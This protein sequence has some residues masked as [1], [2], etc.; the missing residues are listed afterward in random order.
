MSKYKS[1][2]GG[3][4]EVG[5]GTRSVFEGKI[6]LFSKFGDFLLTMGLGKLGQTWNRGCGS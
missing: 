1:G 3:R 5:A 6:T 2:K 4:E